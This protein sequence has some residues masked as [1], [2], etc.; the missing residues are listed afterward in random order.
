MPGPKKKPDLSKR[1]KE[2]SGKHIVSPD[3]AH[4]K[5]GGSTFKRTVLPSVATKHVESESL[6]SELEEL[7]AQPV[8]EADIDI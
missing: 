5:I 3:G 4:M 7:D 2:T 8:K 1:Y 6:A